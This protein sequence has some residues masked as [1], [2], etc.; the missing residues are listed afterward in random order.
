MCYL[1][2]GDNQVCMYIVYVCGEINRS[3]QETLRVSRDF[4]NAVWV[5][6]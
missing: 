2:Q 4:N 3:K 6:T 1:A 5:C